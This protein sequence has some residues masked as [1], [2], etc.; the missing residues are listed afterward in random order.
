MISVLAF[1][2]TLK[3]VTVLEKKYNNKISYKNKNTKRSK[4]APGVV[5]NAESVLDSP[6]KSISDDGNVIIEIPLNKTCPIDHSESATNGDPKVENGDEKD[7]IT[8]G[9]AKFQITKLGKKL[10]RKVTRPKVLKNHESREYLYDRLYDTT[11]PGFV[12][13]N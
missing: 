13:V 5:Q 6:L 12:S 10:P 9:V 8:E 3:S 7:K 1:V 11:C 4:M 2:V